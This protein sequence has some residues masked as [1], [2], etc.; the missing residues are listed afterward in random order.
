MRYPYRSAWG[1]TAGPA[2]YG[3][4]RGVRL[5][6]LVGLMAVAALGCK[7]HPFVDTQPL[8]QAGMTYSNIQEL[9]GLD[10]TN[11]EIAEIAKAR[12]AGISDTGC[13]ELVRF[14][15]G[16]KEPFSSGGAVASLRQVG[17]SEPTVL[18]LARLNQ[19]GL[20]VGEAQAMRLVGL[21][22][23]VLLAIARRR[24]A[25]QPAL[26]GPSVGR[27]KNA[28]LSEADILAGIEQGLTDEQAEEV[29]ATRRR[30]A[31]GSTFV[32]QYRRRR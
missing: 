10:V 4:R 9:K 19:L 24:A 23:K 30:A 31:G 12:Q 8:D 11:A 5:V 15:R 2:A 14:A 1:N 13:I 16:R 29:I 6:C 28:G 32:R 27:L 26:S 25:G 20:W 22:D 18:E 7:H 21:S 17:V 3:T